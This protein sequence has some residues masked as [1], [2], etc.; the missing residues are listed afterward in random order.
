MKETDKLQKEFLI[1][2]GNRIREIRLEKGLSQSEVANLCG[3]ERQSY[4]RVESGNIN[5]TIWYLQHIAS[6]LK[7]E[8]KDLLNIDLPKINL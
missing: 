2:L 5:P 3:K 1:K 4:Q 8:V 7:V 6:A